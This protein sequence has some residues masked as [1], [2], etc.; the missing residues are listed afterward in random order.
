M[1]LCAMDHDIMKSDCFEKFHLAEGE[2]YCL[3]CG[4]CI[5]FCRRLDTGGA[6]SL[7]KDCLLCYSVCPRMR[8]RSRDLVAGGSPMGNFQEVLQVKSVESPIGAQDSGI[9][10]L[11]AKHLLQR[12]YVEAVLLTRRRTDWSPEPFLATRPEEVEQASGTKYTVSPALS[13]FREGISQFRRLAVVGLPCQVEA[14]RNFLSRKKGL[15]EE[16]EVIFTIGLFCMN[17]FMYGG[18]KHALEKEVGIPIEDIRRFEI[19][20]GKLRIYHSGCREPVVRNVKEFEHLIWPVCLACTDFTSVFSDISVGSVGSEDH[21]NT[22]IIRSNEGRRVL[23][24]LKEE[25]LVEIKGLKELSSIQ[26]MANFKAMRSRN[27]G[28][29]EKRFLSKTTVLGNCLSYRSRQS[30]HRRFM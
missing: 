24:E 17:S 15:L 29:D 13:L 22:V 16:W 19:T 21:A 25:G 9:T 4:L 26:R 12:G 2:T 7:C 5:P 11:V 6:A 1:H 28:Q 30:K 10:T 20:K 27:L 23:D 14:I 18:M 8:S 3:H